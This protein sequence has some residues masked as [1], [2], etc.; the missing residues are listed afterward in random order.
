MKTAGYIGSAILIFF[1]VLFVWGAFGANGQPAWIL[2]GGIS[3]LAGLALI[4]FIQRKSRMEAPVNVTLKVDLP[5][6]TKMEDIK[7]KSCGGSLAPENVKL[8]NGAAVVTCPFCGTTY[9]LTEQ[10]K[11]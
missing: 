1:G 9:T 8:A 7:C 3:I 6:E 10:P 5:G 2:V 11:W 4:F